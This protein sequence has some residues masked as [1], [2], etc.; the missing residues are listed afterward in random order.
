MTFSWAFFHYSALLLPSS[1]GKLQIICRE[2]ICK[3]VLG[4]P[5]STVNGAAEYRL[6][7]DSKTEKTICKIAKFWY[8][9]LQMEQE[10]LWKC[11]WNWQRGNLKQRSW[12]ASL[13]EELYKTGL[14]YAWQNGKD[15]DI[16]VLYQNIVNRCNNIEKQTKIQRIREN[17]SLSTY[18]EMKKELGREFYTS[19]H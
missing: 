13:R 16:S 17:K 11:C 4:L 15:S 19:C 12:A 7:G 5:P 10:E 8:R 1:D 2:N 6:G 3:R 18:G 14:G 9:I